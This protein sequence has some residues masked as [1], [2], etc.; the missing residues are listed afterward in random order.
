MRPSL[1]V[2]AGS[3]GVKPIKLFSCRLSDGT[4]DCLDD[5]GN[6]CT[7]KDYFSHATLVQLAMIRDGTSGRR[8]RCLRRGHE[9]PSQLQSGSTGNC[10]VC[11]KAFHNNKKSTE[12]DSWCHKRQSSVGGADSAAQS[13]VLGERL[14]KE[15]RR[16][17]G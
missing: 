5:R 1:H 3:S 16:L 2:R 14:D 10:T 13:A 6:F 15:I 8:L 17:A 4:K 7:G 9:T 12:I 11:K